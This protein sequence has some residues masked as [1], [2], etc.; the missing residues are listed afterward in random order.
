MSID[1]TKSARTALNDTANWIDCFGG[2]LAGSDACRDTAEKLKSELTGPCGE[3]HLEEFETHPAAFMSFHRISFTVYVISTLL[4]IL[5]Q[6]IPAAVGF[7]SII[8]IGM[9]EFGVYK[10]LVDFLYPKKT[11]QNVWAK[12]EPQ[13]EARQQIIISGHH[14]SA[15]ELSFLRSH[16]K[17]YAFRIILPDWFQMLGVVYSLYWAGYRIFTG[18]DP[19]YW[20]LPTAMLFIGIFLFAP[21]FFL[22]GPKATPGAGDN[23]IAS[24]M[25]VELARQASVQ[26]G[27]SRLQHTRLIFVSFDAEEA[28][29]R[30]SRAFARRHSSELQSLPTC[31]LNIDSI[32]N[33]DDLQFLI[34][35]LNGYVPLSGE[36]VEEC[37]EVSRQAGI[38]VRTMKMIF[39]GGAT[40]ACELAKVG[41]KA[42][43]LIAMPT[44]LIRDG[45]AYH[46]I[47]DT[48]EAIEPGAV[49]ACLRIAW[50]WLHWKDQQPVKMI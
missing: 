27:R 30:G 41:V 2:R 34:N 11:C 1:I 9:L 21:K 29:L 46:T 39:G 26:P 25:A 4:L 13:G 36:V 5:R 31:M 28:G 45:L 16:Q 42:T 3:A 6:P 12:L 22:A 35:D 38:P 40:D 10:E 20:Q 43:T 49:E 23:L 33:L 24:A 19:A 8:T 18:A 50:D 7:V 48:V 17:L 47:N 44:G 14:D 15:H 32:Y 37:L